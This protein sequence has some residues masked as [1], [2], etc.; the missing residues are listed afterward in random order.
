MP[1]SEVEV[2]NAL[3]T[4]RE[5]ELRLD[6]VGLDMVRSVTVKGNDV[7]VVLVGKVEKEVAKSRNRPS[8]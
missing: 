8:H 3:A 6:I 5:P 7:G 4:V 2:L 1:L